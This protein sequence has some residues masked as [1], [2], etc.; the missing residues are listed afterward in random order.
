MIHWLLKKGQPILYFL[1]KK[2]Y[3]IP[4]RI[5]KRGIKI[6][7]LPTVFHPSIYKSTDVLLDFLLT[8]PIANKNILELG[9]GNGLISLFLSK[10]KNCNVT[11]TDINPNAIKGLEESQ[12]LNDVQLE[13]LESNLFDKIPLQS[14]DYIL[15]N[16]PFYAKTPKTDDEY[17]FYC[18]VNF[19]YFQQF[20]FQLQKFLM[21][22][23]ICYLILSNNAPIPAI[24]SIAENFNLKF[25]TVSIQS[26]STEELH[27]FQLERIIK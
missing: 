14:F 26:F 4:R 23:T 1:I 9:A 3:S 8:Q 13:V 12:V 2:Y 5:N 15:V 10:F 11:A 25:L 21:P 18:G 24:H 16:P 22:N 20:Y 17:A 27:I 7:L 19:E 6:Q